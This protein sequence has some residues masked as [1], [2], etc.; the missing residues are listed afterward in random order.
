MVETGRV[1]WVIEGNAFDARSGSL[2]DF[3]MR[4]LDRF[5]CAER[6]C[7]SDR[8]SCGFKFRERRIEHGFD[9][10]EELD[11]AFGASRSEAGS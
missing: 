5:S 10:A 6:L 2:C 11:K 3:I 7:R 8:Q 4:E 1:G 9:T